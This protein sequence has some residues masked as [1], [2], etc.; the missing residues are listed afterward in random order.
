MCV[1]VTVCVPVCVCHSWVYGFTVA[2]TTTALSAI[3]TIY[4]QEPADTLTGTAAVASAMVATGTSVSAVYFY[5]SYNSS[6]NTLLGSTATPS[7]ASTVGALYT[8]VFDSTQFTA[9]D[10]YVVR[11]LAATVWCYC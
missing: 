6:L 5:L 3:S 8:I 4:I 1:R 11:F 9:L 10:G 2:D 7:N